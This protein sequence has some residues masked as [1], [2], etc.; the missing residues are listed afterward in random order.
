MYVFLTQFKP[1][2][3]ISASA[4]LQPRSLGLSERERVHE[5]LTVCSLHRIFLQ[6]LAGL[7]VSHKSTGDIR[8]EQL[9][10][11]RRGSAQWSIAVVFFRFASSRLRDTRFFH[12]S[13]SSLD[14]VDVETITRVLVTM[15]SLCGSG[16]SS[17]ADAERYEPG[18]YFAGFAGC[19]Q[20]PLSP[21]KKK[22]KKK[23]AMLRP[24]PA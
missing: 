10:T 5:N 21:K 9:V 23:V 17:P 12:A 24:P 18:A 15:S 6:P 16:S 14:H 3:V 4:C 13:L 19:S 11:R 1:A 8:D 7:A 22:K 2:R 20:T